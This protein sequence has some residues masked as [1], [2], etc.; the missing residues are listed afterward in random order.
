MNSCCAFLAF[1]SFNGLRSKYRK[2]FTV[3]R[4][5]AARG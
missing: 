5:L 2:M 1:K 3:L 4:R